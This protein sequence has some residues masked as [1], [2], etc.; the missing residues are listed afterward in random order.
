M[1]ILPRR[2][3][4]FSTS[5]SSPLWPDQMKREVGLNARSGPGSAIGSKDTS[6]H[7]LLTAYGDL[8]DWRQ[9]LLAQ[10]W[11]YRHSKKIR[12]FV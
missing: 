10:P 7:R 4:A 3:I 6:V 2:L 9:G 12:R 8:V 5:G 1:S 11:D